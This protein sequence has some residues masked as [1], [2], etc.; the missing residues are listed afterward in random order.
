I[1]SAKNESVA[2]TTAGGGISRNRIPSGG[3]D[4]LG[5][6]G[7]KPCRGERG[8]RIACEYDCDGSGACRADIGVWPD[9]WG[10][11][12]PGG[13]AERCARGRHALEGNT[14][15]HRSASAG[16]DGWSG[17]GAWYVRIAGGLALAACSKRSSAAFQRIRR[18]VRI[19]VRDLGMFEA[20][21]G[22]S[23]I[24]GWRVHYG[25]VLVPRVPL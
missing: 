20:A 16:S 13:D 7:G 2:W 11:L 19:D 9:I 10:A 25:G 24:R 21:A 6:H 22:C 15:L 5:D 1:G 14:R 3:R 8:D 12:Q 17:S 4:R 23:G 18:D